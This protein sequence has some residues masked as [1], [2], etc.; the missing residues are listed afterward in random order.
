M[1][2]AKKILT[3][4]A[5]GALTV[6]AVPAQAQTVAWTPAAPPVETTVKAPHT[7]EDTKVFIAPWTRCTNGNRE[8]QIVSGAK[9]GP[10]K[11][12]ATMSSQLNPLNFLPLQSTMTLKWNNANT[13]QHGNLTI[14]SGHFETIGEQVVGA[15]RVHFSVVKT[16]AVGIAGSSVPGTEAVTR[17]NWDVTFAPC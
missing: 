8:L 11:D 9:P 5:I 17:G 2:T 4:L 13:G 12:P 10:S 16:T 14:N 1:K 7:R 15:G 6:S 3:T